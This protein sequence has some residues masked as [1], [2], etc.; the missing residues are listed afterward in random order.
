MQTKPQLKISEKMSRSCLI[1]S[2]FQMYYRSSG[3]KTIIKNSK[4]NKT[5]TKNTKKSH[6]HFPKIPFFKKNALFSRNVLFFR[7]ATRPLVHHIV[8]MT[9]PDMIKKSSTMS[10]IYN[11]F[12]KTEPQ[13]KISE[14]SSGLV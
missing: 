1:F 7:R 12:M 13:L 6:I 10:S 14:K 3:V 5:T 2:D 11:R 8:F 9:D 4:Q